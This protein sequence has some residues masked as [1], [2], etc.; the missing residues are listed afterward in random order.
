MERKILPVCLIVI[1]IGLALIFSG[2]AKPGAVTGGGWMPSQACPGDLC[3]DDECDSKANFGFNAS[4]CDSEPGCGSYSIVG[5]FNYIDRDAV[6]YDGGVKMNGFV[7]EAAE[8][9]DFYPGAE[10]ECSFCKE[11]VYDEYGCPD[12]ERVYYVKVN[13]RST[14]PRYR[15]TGVAIACVADNGEGINAIT[16]DMAFVKAIEGPFDGY[17]NY[18]PVQGNIQAHECDDY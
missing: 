4:T 18:G 17:Y 1:F 9:V 15:G 13:Y 2:C 16:A 12:C 3:G 11:A 6:G 10:V 14:N 7:V 8:C 5:H